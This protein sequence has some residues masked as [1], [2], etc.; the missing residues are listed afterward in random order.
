M[1]SKVI[2]IGGFSEVIELVTLSNI[3]IQGIVD[4]I[5]PIDSPYK[6]LGKDIDFMKSDSK[7]IP[8]VISPDIPFVR[9]KISEEY[10]KE[11]FIFATIVSP[12]AI[13]SLS[14]KIGEGSIIQSLAHVSSNVILG[15]F[16]KLN[17]GANVMHDSKI[18]DYSTI[19]PN[20]VILGRVTIGN[21]CYIGANA[22][23]LPGIKIGDNV[24]VGAG[25][26]VTKDVQENCIVAGVPAKI[27]RLL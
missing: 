7:N 15:S 17:V 13:I 1:K 14:S 6:Y 3:S 11:G 20:A 9:E 19:A 12:K 27:K 2:I 25:A 21:G 26:V 5:R 23:I 22:T 4:P 24:T 16:C 10:R 18:G 8:I